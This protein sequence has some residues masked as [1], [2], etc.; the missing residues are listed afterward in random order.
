[1]PP[2]LRPRPRLPIPSPPSSPRPNGTTTPAA[3][4][5]PRAISTR[6]AAS[7]ISPCRSCWNLPAAPAPTRGSATISIGSSIASAPR[8]PP[9]SPRATASARARPSRPDRRAARARLDVRHAGHA[10][11]GNG[12][13]RAHR[14]GAGRAR[15][16]DPAERS[17]PE[18]HRAV[19]RPAA[20][21][22]PVGHGQRRPVPADDPGGLQ[23]RRPAD[24]SRLHPADRE[25]LQ[26]G[27][28]VAEERPRRVAVHARDRRRA[29]PRD[30]LVR[31]RALGSG[32]VDPRRGAVPEV[33][34]QPVR[35]LAPGAGFVQRRPRPRAARRRAQ[36]DLGLLGAVGRQAAPAA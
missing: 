27:G 17:R 32:E 26:A 11:R 10:D 30:Q 28:A 14:S 13:R 29:R 2:R 25:R 5:W 9:R 21:P 15:H 36:R 31:R 4:S 12:R 16:P 19:P 22:H 8:K 18:L 3:A 23:G 6:P 1:M 35:R 24:G 7:S 33:A 34:L 20:R